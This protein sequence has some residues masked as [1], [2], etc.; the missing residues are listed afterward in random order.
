[1]CPYIDSILNRDENAWFNPL[2]FTLNI[3]NTISESSSDKDKMAILHENIHYIQSTTTFFGINRFL[4]IWESISE[5]ASYLSTNNNKKLTKTQKE[6]LKYNYYN[7]LDKIKNGFITDPIE[8]EAQ[9][10]PGPIF[11]D[12]D[13]NRYGCYSKKITDK[14]HKLFVIDANVLQENMAMAI[15]QW[16]GHSKEIY[17][18]A[19]G[20]TD[21]AFNYVAGTE[22]IKELTKWSDE[23]VLLLSIILSDIAL[24]HVIPSRIFLQGIVLVLEK[25]KT[26]NGISDLYDIYR[27]IYDEF[28]YPEIANQREKY[29]DFIEAMLNETSNSSDKF[30]KS[31]SSILSVMLKAI[32]LRKRNPVAFVDYLLNNI[33]DSFM[34]KT[35]FIP[36][37][38]SK[39]KYYDI[40]KD[41]DSSN[42]PKFVQLS[43]HYLQT[44]IKPVKHTNRCPLYENESCSFRGVTE[45]NTRPWKRRPINNKLCFYRFVSDSFL[46]S[47]P[48]F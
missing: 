36:S 21:S 48:S 13:E 29:R 26:I 28:E 4:R 16:Y 27:F 24:N 37:Y 6:L 5:L 38:L 45:C 20:R 23:N 15:E 19:K 14:K 43:F 32:D 7:N 10:I 12:L 2:T 11:I 9:V 44:F 42:A 18:F 3:P 34:T 46:F 25:W 22:C 41:F 47:K 30:D 35:F 1:M 39:N 8:T 17:D 40:D 31:I 33:D